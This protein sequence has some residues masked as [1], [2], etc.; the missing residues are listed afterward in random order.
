MK[1]FNNA[2][3]SIPHLLYQAIEG[4]GALKMGVWKQQMVPINEMA[5]VLKVVKD[6]VQVKPKSWVRCKRGIYKDDIAQVKY[7]IYRLISS[8]FF[9]LRRLQF[10]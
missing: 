5:D 10:S 6:I 9:A 2:K 1:Y 7:L 4:F 8:L 3:N